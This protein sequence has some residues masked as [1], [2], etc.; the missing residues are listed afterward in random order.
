MEIAA[1]DDANDGEGAT[2]AICPS[3]G[4]EYLSER[5]DE[6]PREIMGVRIRGLY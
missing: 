4:Q 1:S 5:M 6:R 2:A 3:E